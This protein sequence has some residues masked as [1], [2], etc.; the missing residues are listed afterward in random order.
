MRG[1]VAVRA[2]GQPPFDGFRVQQIVPA[3]KAEHFVEHDPVHL[4][5]I[6]HIAAQPSLQEL[7]CCLQ[8]EF[9]SFYRGI[10]KLVV[11]DFI[12]VVALQRQER[13]LQGCEGSPLMV[14]VQR[15]HRGFPCLGQ[16]YR[17]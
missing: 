15:R 16:R 17:C 2:V 7:S 3:G 12:E 8:G 5:W 10:A 4:A 9:G 11:A 13:L 1:H 14:Y 6:R